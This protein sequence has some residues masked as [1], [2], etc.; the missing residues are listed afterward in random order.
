M[1]VNII[2]QSARHCKRNRQN[3]QRKMK[4]KRKTVGIFRLIA[5]CSVIFMIPIAALPKRTI[6]AAGL[7]SPTP[8][9]PTVITQADALKSSAPV[10]I[11]SDL[12]FSIYDVPLCAEQQ[13]KVVDIAKKYSVD[14][15]L[16][17]GIMYAESGY[18][19][20]AQS[21]GGRDIGIM[22]I[23][24][25]NF[26]MLRKALGI[27]DLRDFEQNV[28]CGAYLISLYM[29]RFDSTDEILM[30]YHYGEAGA[31]RMWKQGLE[32]DSYC[33]KVNAEMKRI[34]ASK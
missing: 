17:F 18:N 23:N 33:E 1:S 25:N 12:E 22:Q 16:L 4:R 24:K 19:R 34:A 11:P 8:N 31:G 2:Y 5:V 10:K 14:P 20:N 29:K 32:T 30:C 26:L 28:T 3:M 13:H 21:K 9:C 7:F 15:V 27:T 6:N